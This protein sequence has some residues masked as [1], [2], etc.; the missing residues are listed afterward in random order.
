MYC[1]MYV[2]VVEEVVHF[3]T[4][5]ILCNLGCYEINLDIVGRTMWCYWIL[6]I[7]LGVSSCDCCLYIIICV[8]VLW[9]KCEL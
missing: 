1:G 4:C 2:G 5:M 9:D 3:G 7:D 6:C 8:W